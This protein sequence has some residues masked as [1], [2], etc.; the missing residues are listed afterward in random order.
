MRPLAVAA[1]LG[2]LVLPAAA[3]TPDSVAWRRYFPLAV[4]NAWEYDHVDELPIGPN[5]TGGTYV[6]KHRLR[7]LAEHARQADTLY[8]VA[9]DFVEREARR[10][11]LRDTVWVR[12]DNARGAVVLADGGGAFPYPFML[13]L[14]A[15]L[16]GWRDVPIHLPV[17]GR[18]QEAFPFPAPFVAKD[19]SSYIYGS[20]YVADVGLLHAG[21]GCEP[22]SVFDG[23]QTWRL[24][25]ATVG[26]TTYEVGQTTVAAE[27]PRTAEAMTLHPSVTRTAATLRLAAPSA[28]E[29][30]DVTG[31]RVYRAEASAGDHRIDVSAWAPGLYVVRAGSETRRLVVR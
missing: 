19:V 30:F 5:G 1:A 28:V 11:P 21:G 10:P 12:Y 16:G 23:Y 15:P 27:R 17:R 9:R 7:V 2:L 31:R 20:V 29:V 8:A 4:G 24:L 22:C 13:G 25:R 26:R 6:W 14:D 3:Q 18:F